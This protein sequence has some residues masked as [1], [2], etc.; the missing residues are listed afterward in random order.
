MFK[1]FGGSSSLTSIIEFNQTAFER[2]AAAI[3]QLAESEGLHSHSESIKM[4]SKSTSKNASSLKNEPP[5]P[6]N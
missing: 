2:T 4:R 5:L 6:Q 3:E 1:I